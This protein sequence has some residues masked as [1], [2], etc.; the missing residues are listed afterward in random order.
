MSCKA[1]TGSRGGWT[2][3]M[4]ECICSGK[5]ASTAPQT[6]IETTKS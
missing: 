4:A 1:G 3:T 6:A 2:S 5:R